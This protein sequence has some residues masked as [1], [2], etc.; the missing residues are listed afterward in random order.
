MSNIAEQYIFVVDDQSK[1][2]EAI[3][4]TLEQVGAKVTCFARGVECLEQLPV[5]RC[6]L[7]IT[8]LRMP[9]MNGIELI[10]NVRHLTPWLPILVVTGYGDI[11][12]AVKTTK[13]G[14]A[15]LIQKPLNKESF[16]NKVE[17]IL[18]EY[19]D[20]RRPDKPLT[21]KELAVLTLV[22][23]GK[24]NKQIASLLHRSVRT[25]EVH[26]SRVMRK[27][28]VNSLVD[29]LKQAAIMGLVGSKKDYSSDVL[30]D[31]T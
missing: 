19:S 12:T 13:A 8:D 17:S 6:D 30:K 18:R 11:P 7:L 27:L 4:E 29:L 24:T 3:S 5:Q 16:V 26:R 9:E 2:C 31:N 15:D 28:G 10:T 20:H 22:I 1:V 25:V 23:E 21:Q 14:A